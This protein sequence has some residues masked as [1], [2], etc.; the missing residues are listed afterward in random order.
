METE[1]CRVR[2]VLDKVGDKWSVSVIGVL[3]RETRRFSEVKRAIPGISQRMLTVTL[4]ALERDGLV[5]RTVYATVPPRVDYALTALGLTLLDS[6]W[7]LMNW[8]LDHVG[9][10]DKARDAYDRQRPEV[11]PQQP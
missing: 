11:P 3:G 10:I 2:E 8:A 4:R 1:D 5:T 7:P 9:E 6:A